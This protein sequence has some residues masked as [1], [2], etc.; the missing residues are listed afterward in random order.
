M[1]FKNDREF[2]FA[3]SAAG[4]YNTDIKTD[5]ERDCEETCAAMDAI[6]EETGGDLLSPERIARIMNTVRKMSEDTFTFVREPLSEIET[7]IP[8][9]LV[10]AEEVDFDLSD[11]G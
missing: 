11:V 1:S 6:L 10:M 9:D 4:K 3:E 8:F 7:D 5:Y 2:L